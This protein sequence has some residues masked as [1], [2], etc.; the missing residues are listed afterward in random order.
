MASKHVKQLEAQKRKDEILV[1]RTSG[2]LTR[3]DIFRLLRGENIYP[4]KVKAIANF[5]N[6]ELAIS[7]L[8]PPGGWH[9]KDFIWPKKDRRRGRPPKK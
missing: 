8:R 5:L 7:P 9:S 3:D 6:A 4:T 1:A 2:K